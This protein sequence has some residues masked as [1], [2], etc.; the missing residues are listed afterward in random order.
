M[1]FKLLFL[2]EIF[3]ISINAQ[4]ES[5]QIDG[6]QGVCQSASTCPYF[7]DDNENNSERCSQETHVCCRE[8]LTQEEAKTIDDI[9]KGFAVQKPKPK[10]SDAD[11]QKGM[12]TFLFTL[13][14]SSMRN[15]EFLAR[16][17]DEK[18]EKMLD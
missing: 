6:A 2:I 16:K 15:E 8:E 4:Q 14:Y 3:I 9:L 1:L 7:V 18:N 11:A 17:T 13:A 10:L 5:C 12:Y